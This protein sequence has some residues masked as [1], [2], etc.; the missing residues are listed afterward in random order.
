[1][2]HASDDVSDQMTYRPLGSSGLMVS[3]VGLG[4]NAFGTRI[5]A[6]Q[7]QQVVDAALDAGITLFDTA[8]SYGR[9]A[10]EELLGKALGSRRDEIVLATKFGM[11]MGGANGPDWG[12]RAS[13]RYVRTAVEASLR[14]LGT[15]H[16]DLYQL[17]Q[18]DL[19][20]PIEET[21]SALDDLVREGKVGYL[22][23]SNFAAWEVVDAHW[24]ATTAG[25]QPFITAQNEYS[26]YNRSAEEE[27]VPACA[28]LGMSILP[29]F[30]LAFGL[31]TGKYRRG[32]AAPSGSRL[33]AQSSRLE[34]ADF[35]RIEALEAFAAERDRTL[36]DVA[37]GG[38]AAQP[39]V[40]SVIAGATKPEQV[41]GNARAGSWQPSAADLAALDE[42]NGHRAPG[43]THASF[44]RR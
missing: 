35:D 26:L 32:E 6:A 25:V 21:L 18:P 9:G 22:G 15:D 8:D 20:T 36:L 34:S 41:V 28:R 37:I 44:T 11:D 19:V 27:L 30:P 38:L 29:Y 31:L 12:A 7:T 13:R 24:T 39:G 10:S 17:H 4:C 3:A 2:D 40:G 43:M 42:I 33:E 1:M 16:I 14:R 5:D 23:C